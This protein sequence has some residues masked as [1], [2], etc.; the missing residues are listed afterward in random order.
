MAWGKVRPGRS[1]AGN[2]RRS[3]SS[4]GNHGGNAAEAGSEIVARGLRE[5]LPV[6]SVQGGRRRREQRQDLPDETAAAAVVEVDAGGAA[7]LGCRARKGV[8]GDKRHHERR[9]DPRE[10][11]ERER[12]SRVVEYDGVGSVE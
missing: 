11:I 6:F 2:R 8:A 4:S 10:P 1:G 3:R 7:V 9:G 12:R 5:A